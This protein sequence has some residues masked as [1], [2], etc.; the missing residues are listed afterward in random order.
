[1]AAAVSEG[2]ASPGKRILVIRRTVCELLTGSGVPVGVGRE[3]E[4]CFRGKLRT[5]LRIETNDVQA[6][7]AR[8]S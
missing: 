5:G 2:D 7:T 3:S 8:Q 4:R 6:G 1:M